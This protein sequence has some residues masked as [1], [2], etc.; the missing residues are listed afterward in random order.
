MLN[1]ED[2]RD[3][4]VIEREVTVSE[5]LHKSVKVKTQNYICKGVYKDEDNTAEIDADFSE[6]N[7]L[8][9]YELNNY[10]LEGLLKA[11]ATFLKRVQPMFNFGDRLTIQELLNGCEGWTQDEIEAVI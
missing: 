9:E 8:Q 11:T 10:T 7:W 2:E 6:T 1:P 3:N 5:T 4:P